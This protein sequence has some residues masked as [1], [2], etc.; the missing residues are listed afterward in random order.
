[1]SAIKYFSRIEREEG[2]RGERR[3]RRRRE[4]GN[5]GREKVITLDFSPFYVK[6][7]LET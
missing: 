3:R 6:K 7:D 4:D 2:G 5:D 1:M